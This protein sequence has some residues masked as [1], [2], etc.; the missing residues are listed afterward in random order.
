MLT[1]RCGPH[2][3]GNPMRKAVTVGCMYSTINYK[4]TIA[5]CINV[6]INQFNFKIPYSIK[7]IAVIR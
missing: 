7:F 3:P 4:P 6:L 1:G 2:S 5:I